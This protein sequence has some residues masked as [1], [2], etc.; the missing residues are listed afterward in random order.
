MRHGSIPHIP[1]GGIQPGGEEHLRQPSPI[2]VPNIEQEPLKYIAL[3]LIHL[4]KEIAKLPPMIDDHSKPFDEYNVQ[5]LA[6]ESTPQIT[7]QPQFESSEIVQGILITG[8][9]AA[10]AT[11][12]LG[13]RVWSV[14]MPASQVL[15]IGGPLGICLSRSDDRILT[16]T[17]ATGEWS[18]E[19]MGY[20]DT[21]GIW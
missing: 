5:T 2:A 4:R 19:L 3:A 12:K 6:V 16:P 20:A 9:A 17:V 1:R 7:L 8:P 18:L 10:T 14:V 13:D 11:L 15:F 21:R